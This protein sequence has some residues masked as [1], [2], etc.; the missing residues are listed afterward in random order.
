MFDYA[1]ANAEH[2]R[3]Q[4]ALDKNPQLVRVDN[5]HYFATDRLI[6]ATNSAADVIGFLQSGGLTVGRF[7]EPEHT[8]RTKV[9]SPRFQALRGA[10]QALG[11]V[12]VE[13]GDAKAVDLVPELRAKFGDSSV[14]AMRYLNLSPYNTGP[15]GPP[16]FAFDLSPYKR[17]VG[18]RKIV[19]AVLD[20]G[21]P[22]QVIHQSLGVVENGTQASG[23][24]SVPEPRDPLYVEGTNLDEVAAAGHGQFVSAI[25]ARRTP[26]SVIVRSYRT[27]ERILSPITVK[28]PGATFGTLV[29]TA[30]IVADL[31]RADQEAGDHDLVV[32]MSFGGWASA[33][34]ETAEHL[35]KLDLDCV[36]NLLL[37]IAR[38]RGAGVLFCAAAGNKA[39]P[40]VPASAERR[41]Y[42]AAFSERLESVVSVGAVD[43]RSATPAPFSGRGVWVN[44]WGEGV[45]VIAE[46]VPGTW[47]NAPGSTY[48]QQTFGSSTPF[49]AWSG[50]SFATPK[51]SAR[52]AELCALNDE[53]PLDVWNAMK[54]TDVI[55]P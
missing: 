1:A 18:K 19:V 20:S 43:T 42:P 26:E 8:D 53:R 38:K 21:L 17:P 52:I 27:T 32:N 5:I 34:G 16:K 45:G 40:G 10:E 33:A 35:G 29:G 25:I 37:Q 3:R 9:L 54:T 31:F 15:A 36:E 30:E 11:V 39:D 2:V 23:S 49:A 7:T 13:L 6:L 14:S 48:A 24:M 41:V 47:T 28:T 12:F 22:S 51:V 50:T 44:A 55:V 46:Y 4:D